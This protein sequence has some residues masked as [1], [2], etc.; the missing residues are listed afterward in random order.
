MGVEFK[1]WF[2]G[3]ILNNLEKNG[4]G[5][6]GYE[7]NNKP[8]SMYYNREDF[9]AFK[10]EMEQCY[11]SLTVKWWHFGGCWAAASAEERTSGTIRP[12][13]NRGS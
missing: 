6:F 1:T 10:D 7:L 9:A 4:Y 3:L 8:Y 2:D 13:G 5:P 12:F 11:R